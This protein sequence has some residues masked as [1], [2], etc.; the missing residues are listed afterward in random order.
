MTTKEFFEKL[1]S[2][3]ALS[4]EQMKNLSKHREE[5]E[6]YLREKFGQEP[7][8]RYAGFEGKRHHDRGKLRP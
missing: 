4:D 5:V 2:S 7:T 6:G 1:L 3:Q 8:I